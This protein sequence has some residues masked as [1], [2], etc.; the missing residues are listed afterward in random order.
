MS[1]L[2]VPCPAGLQ[3]LEVRLPNAVPWLLQRRPPFEGVGLDRFLVQP[4]G[5][6]SR[7]EDAAGAALLLQLLLLC[8]LRPCCVSHPRHLPVRA[9]SNPATASLTPAGMAAWEAQAVHQLALAALAFAAPHTRPEED[10]ELLLGAAAGRGGGGSL[11]QALPFRPSTS[12]VQQVVA[13]VQALATRRRQWRAERTAFLGRVSCGRTQQ[14]VAVGAELA[15]LLRIDLPAASAHLR[16][17]EPGG[18]L[19]LPSVFR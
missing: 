19:D 6:P 2:Y 11:L 7:R 12:A 4:E 14:E 10:V 17:G 8:T 13:S 16:A 3:P 15:R 18:S 5:E 1:A 9:P